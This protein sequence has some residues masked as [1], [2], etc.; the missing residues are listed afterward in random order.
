M[1]DAF[2]AFDSVHCVGYGVWE[3]FLSIDFN[4]RSV[5]ESVCKGSNNQFQADP[6]NSQILP[7]IYGPAE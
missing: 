6:Q 4:I 5:Y 2:A 7:Q 3:G 1:G